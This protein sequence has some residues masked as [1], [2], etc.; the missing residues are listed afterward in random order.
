MPSQQR[1]SIFH[2]QLGNIIYQPIVSVVTA[3]AVHTY[4]LLVYIDVAGNAIRSGFRKNQGFMATP[5]IY[6][7]VLPRQFKSSFTVVKTHLVGACGVGS[8][9]VSRINGFPVISPNTPTLRRMAGGAVDLQAH[10]MWVLRR[11][12]RKTNEKHED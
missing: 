11:Q 6:G 2:M 12:I 8:L 1:E 5:A 9:R 10:T 7:G 4:R 3:G